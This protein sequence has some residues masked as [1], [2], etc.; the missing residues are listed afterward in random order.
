MRFGREEQGKKLADSKTSTLMDML[1]QEAERNRPK[2]KEL[3]AQWNVVSAP[4]TAAPPIPV[5][6][7]QSSQS[8]RGTFTL[9]RPPNGPA[10]PATPLEVKKVTE[11][12]SYKMTPIDLDN[13]DDDIDEHNPIRR[14]PA[15]AR[16]SSVSSAVSQQCQQGLSAETIF[17]PSGLAAC[18]LTKIFETARPRYHKRTSSA[19]WTHSPATALRKK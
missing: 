12:T 18:D 10:T 6:S 16:S 7:G 4:S 14:I 13:S 8:H 3:F 19:V 17:S 9:P 2:L 15:W 5:D 1:R 11:L